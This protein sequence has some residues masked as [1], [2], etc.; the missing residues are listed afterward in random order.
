VREKGKTM[1][2]SVFQSAIKALL[3][4]IEINQKRQN[5]I[6]SLFVIVLQESCW[7]RELNLPFDFLK[8]YYAQFYFFYLVLLFSA[9]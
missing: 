4:Q 8:F 5:Y 1:N 7:F 3:V 9:G 2:L 6:S